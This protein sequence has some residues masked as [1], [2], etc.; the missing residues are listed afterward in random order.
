MVKDYRIFPTQEQKEKI[1]SALGTYRYIF[2]RCIDF[3]K[4]DPG[5]RIDDR[6][7]A[8]RLYLSMKLDSIEEQCKTAF[9]TPIGT[10][11]T[12]KFRWMWDTWDD[13]FIQIACE[14]AYY[15]AKDISPDKYSYITKKDTANCGKIC[16]PVSTIVCNSIVD[17]IN[18]EA[19]TNNT[20]HMAHIPML[21]MVA[22]QLPGQFMSNS[23]SNTISLVEIERRIGREFT[24]EYYLR[25]YFPNLKDTSK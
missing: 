13:D 6:E 1:N 16:I 10:E 3:L 4:N 9:T 24:E 22:I 20:K 14:W 2:N 12:T 7:V 15:T 11:P 18:R 8:F 19:E 5:L 23:D 21:G 17:T 25:I